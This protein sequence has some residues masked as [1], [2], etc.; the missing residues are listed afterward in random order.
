MTTRVMTARLAARMA[1]A[2]LWLLTL[3]ALALGMTARSEAVAARILQVDAATRT[4]VTSSEAAAIATVGGVAEATVT[5]WML[6]A[7]TIPTATTTVQLAHGTGTWDVLVAAT[8]TAAA[9][10]SSTGPNPTPVQRFYVVSVDDT[11]WKPVRSPA[12]VPA[13]DLAG[14]EVEVGGP[15]DELPPDAAATI[16]GFLDGLLADGEAMDRYVTPDSTIRAV[17]PAPYDSVTVDGVQVAESD[18]TAATVTVHATGHAEAIR[19]QPLQYVLQLRHG[20]RWEVVA[21]VNYP[22]KDTES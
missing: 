8:V 22:D 6:A 11:T 9:D 19:S 14:P 18:G 15:L 4:G 5:A 17:V 13:P 10:P 21:I 20:T 3:S 1:A 7:D 2:C 16:T 12:L